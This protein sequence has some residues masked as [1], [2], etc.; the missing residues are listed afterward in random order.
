MYDGYCFQCWVDLDSSDLYELE[1]I[2]SG[3]KIFHHYLKE[4]QLEQL[5][6]L[7][8]KTGAPAAEIIRRALDEYLKKQK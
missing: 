4:K 3:V 8:E 6:K 2:E 1:R 5:K 7:S